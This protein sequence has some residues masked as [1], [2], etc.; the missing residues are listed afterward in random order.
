MSDGTRR[1]PEWAPG[2]YL[3]RLS[4]LTRS[5]L[6]ALGTRRQFESG[7]QLLREGAQDTHLE[8]LCRGFV[9][10]TTVAEGR[11]TLLAIRAAGDILGETAAFTG[12]ARTATVTACGQ[13]TSMVL[14]RE[15]FQRF[16]DQHGDAAR[17][18]TAVVSER[19]WWANQ[20]RTEFAAYPADVRLARV[21]A[22]VATTCGL[23]ADDG[24]RLGVNLSQ[25]ELAT[26][27]GASEA[28]VHKA[29]R[30]LRKGDLIRTGYRR[31]VI[32]DIN[33]LRAMGEGDNALG[34][35]VQ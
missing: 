30:D 4:P 17:H 19:H 13:V 33:A 20:R 9:K 35:C 28:T 11:E 22:E 7:R 8:L 26:L 14:A 5:Q 6:L 1:S 34:S 24:I 27:I 32:L 3:D 21:L 31:I 12:R 10:V 29:L 16:L 23:E 15:A 2:S 18:L 25:P